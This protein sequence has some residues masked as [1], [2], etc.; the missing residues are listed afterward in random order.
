MKGTLKHRTYTMWFS[1]LLLFMLLSGIIF[2]ATPY[3]IV[4][5]AGE[6]T[7]NNYSQE[8]HNITSN[9]EKKAFNST[10]SMTEAQQLPVLRSTSQEESEWYFPNFLYYST[11]LGNALIDYLYDNETGGFYRSTDEHWLPEN[12]VKEKWTYDQAQ[13]IRAFLK[14]SEALINE[15]QSEYAIQIANETANYMIKNLWD[16]EYGGFYINDQGPGYKIPAVQGQ[17]IMALVD[18]FKVTG[19]QTFLDIALECLNF[20]NDNGWDSTNGGYYYV[21]AH[22]GLV[23]STNPFPNNPYKPDSKRVDHNVLMGKALLEYYQVSSDPLLLSRAIDVYQFI[24]STSRNSTTN[25]YYTGV[26][27]NNQTVEPS[28]ADVF[29]QSQ[30]LDFLAQLYNATGNTIYY[31]DFFTL[32]NNVVYYF[33]DDRYGSFYATYSYDDPEAEDIQKFTERQFYTIR[34][35]DE[36]YKLVNSSLYYNIILDVLEVTNELLYDHVHEGYYQWMNQGGI[37]SDPSSRNKFTVTQALAIYELANLWLHSKPGVLNAL[38]SPSQPRPEDGVRITIAA[39][40]SDGIFNVI[41]NYSLNNEPYRQVEMESDSNIGNMYYSTFSSQL[42]GTTVN[43]NVNVNDTLGNIVVR[44]SYFFLWQED[45]W[46]P[47]IEEVAI[48]PN[49][50]VDVHNKLSMTVFAQDIPSQGSVTNVRVYIRED[51]KIIETKKLT[52]IS[53]TFWSIEFPDGF[54]SPHDFEYYYEAIDGQ[55]N[56]GHSITY[57]LII[58]GELVPFPITFVLVAIFAIVI[59]IPASLYIYVERKKKQA[60]RTLKGV[61]RQRRLVSRSKRG[62]RRAMRR[63][64]ES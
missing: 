25:L 29:I 28:Y 38:W 13:A 24:N 57:R 61:Q 20:M 41:L 19:N 15:S 45:V 59:L 32:L 11:M 48:A 55:G 31:D 3:F 58:Y 30:V 64:N 22:I 52:S 6:I 62:T 1:I 9:M 36:A 56:I 2:S 23:A 18:L 47:Y 16:S 37:P 34:A 53:G 33:W 10:Y 42:D 40:D 43:F 44:G 21:L 60:R 26:D 51:G 39:F 14:L 49:F 7:P 27:V 50:E 4:F 46:G 63:K 17:A 8:D 5:K 12:I 35:L 54:S